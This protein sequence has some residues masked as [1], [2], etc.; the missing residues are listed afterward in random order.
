M[1]NNA[2]DIK[3]RCSSLGHIMANDRSG[4]NIGEGVY[5]HL[6][7]IFASA[8]YGRREEI[9]SK[10]LDKG[11]ACENDAIT[12]LSRV[13][14][15]FYVKNDIRLTNDFV[16][17]ELDL[18]IGEKVDKAKE[19]T[20]TKTSW[21]LHTFLRSKQK[22]L[23]INYYWQGHGYMWLSGS[24]KHTV[25]YCLVNG[26]DTA[27]IDEKRKLSWSYGIDHDTNP[28][29]VAKCKQIEIN[30]I[31]DLA[32]FKKHYPFFQFHN[33]LSEWVYDIPKEERV[34]STSFEYSESEIFKLK[35][36]IIDC[37]VWMNKELFKI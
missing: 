37:R 11:H 24:K 27:I 5:A 35:S 19:T 33:D 3:F 1:V 15:T 10:Y 16:T 12:L 2:N 26:T 13:T 7:D 8:K 4:K 30:H 28:E 6:V 36:R 32:L 17:G 21:S 18:F 34:H 9:T 22:K 25:S 29:Y 20:D 31:F 14:K 23:D